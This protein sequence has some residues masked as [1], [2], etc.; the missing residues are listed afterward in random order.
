MRNIL[1]DDQWGAIRATA[2]ANSIPVKREF[3]WKVY[4]ESANLNVADIM[5]K[6]NLIAKVT[7]YARHSKWTVTSLPGGLEAEGTTHNDGV[8]MHRE[9]AQKDAEAEVN[10]LLDDTIYD[11]NAPPKEG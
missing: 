2:V 6:R 11:G 10:R 4:P 3:K 1:S 8:V 5:A 7:F 9:Q